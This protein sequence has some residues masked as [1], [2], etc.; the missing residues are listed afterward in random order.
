MGSPQLSAAGAIALVSA[1]GLDA[2][3]RPFASASPDAKGTSRLS[4]LGATRTPAQRQQARELAS[5]TS[6][7]PAR[8]AAPSR[9]TKKKTGGRR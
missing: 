8:R 2:A 5:G 6:L 7:P 1:R 4:W 9:S 3:M